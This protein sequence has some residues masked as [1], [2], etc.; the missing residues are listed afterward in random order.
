MRWP[1]HKPP[2]D[3][4][5]QI[6]RAREERERSERALAHAR[7]HVIGPLTEIRQRNHLAEILR[8]EIR[9]GYRHAPQG[10]H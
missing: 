4:S 5:D 10:D 8:D 2:P 6:R 3:Q 1:W 9:R 7:E